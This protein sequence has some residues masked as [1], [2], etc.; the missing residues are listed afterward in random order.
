MISKKRIAVVVGVGLLALA[1]RFVVSL[2]GGLVTRPPSHVFVDRHGEFLGEVPTTGGA[3]GYWPLPEVLPER[4]VV[5][6]L[7][8]ED[9]FFHQHP[10]VAWPSV[11]RAGWQNLTHGRVVSGASTLAMQVA[12]M[13]SPRSR[14]PWAKAHE[15]ATALLLVHRHGHDVVLRQ[16]LTIAPYGER[17]HGAGRASKLYFAKPVEDLSWLQA[18]F[19]AGLPQQPV[20]FSP[21]HEAG[22]ARALARA[23]RILRALH[24]RG[25][26]DGET[27]R[28][29]LV[30]E[31]GLVPRPV[32]PPEAMHAF[33]AVAPMA[34]QPNAPLERFTSFD[35]G[36]QRRAAALTRNQLEK[37]RTRGAGNAALLLT[38]PRTGEVLA[39]V[40]SADYFD[41]EAKGAIDF[42]ATKRSPG[43]ALK[44]YLYALALQQGKA[45]L[46]TELPDVPAEFPTA[47][48]A[49]VPENIG[50]TW[51]GP[52]L[53]REALANSRNLPALHVLETVGVDR[54]LDLFARGGVLGIA[55]DPG[56]Y[57]LTLALGALH[58]TPRELAV[59][60]S[61]LSNDG[62]AV[63]LRFDP[64]P[65]LETEEPGRRLFEPHVAQAITHVLADPQARRPAFPAGGPLDFD[66][67]VAVKTG[68]SQGY[69]DAW[70]V[71]S[72]GDLLAIAWVGN[73]DWRRMRQ[74]T[75]ALAAAPLVHALLDA[76]SPSFP[77][78]VKS[79]EG[80]RPFD[81]CPLSGQRPGPTCP[82]RKV[83]L[84]A[85]GTE[86]TATCPYHQTVA[87]DVR[88]Q[89]RAGPACPRASVKQAPML[90][91]PEKYGT[92][93]RAQHLE[94]APFGESPLCPTSAPAPASVAIREPRSR[95]RYL[96]DP[97]T[98]RELSTVQLRAQ[99]EPSSHEVIWLVDG[100]PVGRVGWPHELRVPLDRG[101]HEIRAALADQPLLSA[102]VTV[103]IDD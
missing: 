83:E 98:P 30:S 36:L 77:S 84:F 71:A 27:L 32:R 6:T 19:L 94:L 37:L 97:A 85:T 87:I 11:L 9:R 29:A 102:P 56:E 44:P 54:A 18:A 4:L 39:Y 14:T 101:R 100:R 68:T 22:R 8:T 3:L 76:A 2:D 67:A 13:Q 35:L 75:G 103:T 64:R 40:G 74:L 63:P 90:A 88:T 70:A 49:W 80:Y 51:L 55:N 33:L 17:V 82:H 23:H 59:L 43:S 78:A 81:V 53:F 1:V 52:M 31:L 89:R 28:Q 25:V 61:S 16:Y 57:G 48:G 24:A 21:W 47:L 20:R 99:V 38:R 86:P 69:R 41:D 15:A 66:G 26:I 95:A 5:A 73:A 93:A 65:V 92:W 45:T 72:S 12:R 60:A 62:V 58:V 46:S 96:F 7:E 91:L 50:H 79:P 34:K 42:L 10:G